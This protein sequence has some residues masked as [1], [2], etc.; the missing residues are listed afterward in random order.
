MNNTKKNKGNAFA[1]SLKE[2]NVGINIKDKTKD[3]IKNATHK[4]AQSNN[5]LSNQLN[6]EEVKDIST[7]TRLKEKNE[8]ATIVRSVS[9]EEIFSNRDHYIAKEKNIFLQLF[10]AIKNN[11]IFLFFWAIVLF[12]PAIATVLLLLESHTVRHNFLTNDGS[13]IFWLLT[14]YIS[15]LVGMITIFYTVRNLSLFI[16]TSVLKK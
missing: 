13:Q 12:L 8:N 10:A 11:F 7:K 3:L 1:L 4:A 16:T 6:F 9:K 14:L 2:D 15:F 5:S